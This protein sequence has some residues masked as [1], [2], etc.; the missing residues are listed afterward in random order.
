[1]HFAAQFKATTGTRPHNYVLRRRIE[2]AQELLRSS[3]MPLVE[4]AL[5]V[6]FQTQAHF[7]TIFRQLVCE[8]PGRW[9]D[10]YQGKLNG[11]PLPLLQKSVHH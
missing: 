1:M 9:R 8:T 6:G 3:H 5:E 11:A 4:I 2:R 7:T 10:L